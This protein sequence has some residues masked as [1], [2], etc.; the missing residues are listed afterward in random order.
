MRDILRSI[1][2][3]DGETAVYLALLELGESATGNIIKKSRVS[4]SKVYE[5]LDRLSAKGLVSSIT[6]NNLRIFEAADP[7]K[8]I[9]YL[10]QKEELLKTE[11]NKINSI[12]PQLILRKHEK[13]K[14]S[15]KVYTG[16]EGMKTANEQIINSLKRGD[17]WLSMG[18]TSQPKSWEIY[19]NKKQLE[20]AKKGIVHKQL[21]NAKYKSLYRARKKMQ[22]TL[23]RFLPEEFEMP[24]STE[25]YGNSVALFILLVED[26]MVIVIESEAVAASFRTYFNHLWSLAGK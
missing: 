1:G 6:R 13:T 12:I 10:E 14:S 19:F 25:I 23:M 8:I 11:K 5:V 15:A 26:P 4:G 7:N 20:R 18:L 22:H 17:E 2:L 3:T 9:S 24:T 21:L 16:F